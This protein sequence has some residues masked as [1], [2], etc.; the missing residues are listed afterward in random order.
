MDFKPDWYVP[1]GETIKEILREKKIL[2]R[3]LAD[4]LKMDIPDLNLLLKG[5]SVLT[6]KIAE[7][8]EKHLGATKK[9]WLNR[10]ETYRK[11]KKRI[12]NERK[13]PK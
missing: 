4:F 7:A 8:L 10:E 5:E 11:D 12:D 1:P 6:E 13:R 9:F 2:R 3:Q